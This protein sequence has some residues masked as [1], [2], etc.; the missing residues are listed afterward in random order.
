[1]Y[2]IMKTVM[3]VG[4]KLALKALATFGLMFLSIFIAMLNITVFLFKSIVVPVVIMGSVV[5]GYFFFTK[6]LGSDI[7][8]IAAGSVTAIGLRYVLPLASPWL[9]DWK[10]SM[11]DYICE[12]LF[13]RSPVKYTM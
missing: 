4:W 11:K 10:E 2:Y 13:I 12:P 3:R 9:E 8:W 7:I 1:M 6:E 5:A